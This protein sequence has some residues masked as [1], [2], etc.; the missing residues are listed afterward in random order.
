MVCVVRF[1][2]R[3]GVVILLRFCVLV[4]VVVWRL[5]VGCC[6]CCLLSR[7]LF[8]SYCRVM[9][10]VNGCWNVGV[11]VVLGVMYC[12]WIGVFIVWRR[13]L[14]MIGCSGLIGGGVIMMF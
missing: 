11:I 14:M 5:G 7:C 8:G 13:F 1:V 12:C 9:I 3:F 2:I 4:W 10:C 6:V